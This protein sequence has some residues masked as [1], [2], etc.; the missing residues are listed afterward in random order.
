MPGTVEG[1]TVKVPLAVIASPV[2]PPFE[3]SVG[4]TRAGTKAAPFSVS[5]V[6]TVAVLPPATLNGTAVKSSFTASITG[7]TTMIT[8]AVSQLVGFATS[9]I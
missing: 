3:T 7:S 9:Q 8:V 4:V 5:L 1:G 2:S 6:N